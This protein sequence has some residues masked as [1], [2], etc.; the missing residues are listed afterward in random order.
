M[1]V[2]SKPPIPLLSKLDPGGLGCRRPFGL[3]PIISWAI[4]H[5]DWSG[6]CRKGLSAWVRASAA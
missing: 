3:V 2:L 6:L 5:K 1:H 4:K